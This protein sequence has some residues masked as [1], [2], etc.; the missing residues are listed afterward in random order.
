MDSRIVK[1]PDVPTL[2]LQRSAPGP[3]IVR[4]GAQKAISDAAAIVDQ[5]R[6]EANVIVQSAKAEADGIRETARED[7]YR[8][9]LSQ[10]NK[11]LQEAREKAGRIL[12]AHEQELVRLAIRAAE[13][14]I[15]EELRHNREAALSIAKNA[16]ASVRRERSVVL[17]VHPDDVSFVRSR[18]ADLQPSAPAIREMHVIGNPSITSGGCIVESEFGN[19]DARLETQLAALE[20]A[21]LR[22]RRTT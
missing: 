9:G 7:G 2:R 1:S 17:H 3:V 22:A 5:A 15:G 6:Q 20:E 10:W 16:L 12:T 14:I 19:I 13:R 11:L 21:A 4:S 18:L 8:E